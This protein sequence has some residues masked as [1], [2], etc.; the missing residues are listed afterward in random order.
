MVINKFRKYGEIEDLYESG[1]LGLIN[2]YK[3]YNKSSKFAS[4]AYYYILGEVTKCLRDKNIFNPNYT[5]TKLLKEINRYKEEYKKVKGKNPSVE[6]ISVSLEIPV[7]KLIELESITSHPMDL[8]TCN[9]IGM[10]DCERKDEIIDLKS[11]FAHLSSF[12][13]KIIKSIYFEGYTEKE[14]GE[15]LGITQVEVSRNK[16]KILKKLREYN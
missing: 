16:T 15:M 8:D 11:S 13:K 4:F 3:H 7:K 2:A 1:V 5:D 14:L 10:K 12:E 6:E 9:N